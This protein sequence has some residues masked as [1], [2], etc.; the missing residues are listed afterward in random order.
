MQQWRPS[1]A[2]NKEI[3]KIKFYFKRGPLGLFFKKDENR[4]FPEFTG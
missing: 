4:D 1:T 3:K 2:K